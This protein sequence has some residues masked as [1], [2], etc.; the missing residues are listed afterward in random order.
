MMKR[1][2]ETTIDCGLARTRLGGKGFSVADGYR[3]SNLEE[4]EES[5]E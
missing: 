2:R 1:E 5:S 3:S 4:E